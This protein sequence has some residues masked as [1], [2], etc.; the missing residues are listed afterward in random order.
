MIAAQYTPLPY[1]PNLHHQEEYTQRGAVG[2]ALGGGVGHAAR[3]LNVAEKGWA[4]WAAPSNR[5]SVLGKH[6][7]NLPQKGWAVPN[8]KVGQACF[9]SDGGLG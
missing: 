2:Q 4:G 8:L 1:L 3:I 7:P 9:L 5:P 6:L